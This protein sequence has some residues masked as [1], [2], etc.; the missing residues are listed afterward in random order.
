MC[1]RTFIAIELSPEIQS[2]LAAVQDK[3]K[4]SGSDV[5]WVKPENIHLTLKFL[6]Y[7]SGPQLKSIFEA[8]DESVER[9][10]P[11]PLFFSGLGAFPGLGNPRVLW[12]GVKEGE[13]MLSRINQNLEGILKRNGFPGEERKYHPHLTL[14]R[15]K[16]S[17]NK[18]QLIGAV[19]SEKDC[20]VGSMEVKKIT[21][22]QS[23]LKP[24]G[25]EYKPL[26][27]SELIG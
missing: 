24:E 27:V 12:V 21:I 18:A 15:V 17:K 20:S 13:E 16:S 14:G 9:I 23:I 7:V 25:P 6:G 3:L 1:I 26:H 4:E 5:K 22:M 8:V 10:T 11:F 19:K 2:E